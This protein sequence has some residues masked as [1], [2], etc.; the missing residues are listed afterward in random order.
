MDP[1]RT[2]VGLFH[3][4][5]GTLIFGT[6]VG[7]M[8]DYSTEREFVELGKSGLD[9]KTVLAML[10]TNPAS[11]MGVSDRKGTVSAGKLADLTI[12]DTDPVTDLTNFSR[13]HAVVR[14][15]KLVWQR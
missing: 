4:L 11:R 15:G 6:D 2:E 7:Y 9:F 3:Q 12:L 1:M 10:T 5:G 13:V 14:S 8:T